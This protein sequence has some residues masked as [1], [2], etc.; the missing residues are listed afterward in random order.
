MESNEANE[1]II[2]VYT[3][4]K[5]LKKTT[6]ICIQT[7]YCLIYNDEYG[8]IDEEL[9]DIHVGLGKMGISET[10]YLSWV[11]LQISHFLPVDL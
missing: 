7:I 1:K 8:S 6:Q 10:I 5:T 2:E 4:E 3:T 11:L 9:T